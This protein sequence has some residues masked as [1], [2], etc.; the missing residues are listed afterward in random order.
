MPIEDD[1]HETPADMV[2]VPGEAEQAAHT[3]Q[4]SVDSHG[5]LQGYYAMNQTPPPPEVEAELAEPK[6]E[7]KDEPKD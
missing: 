3:L 5:T 6:V 4:E 2:E 1:E 7:G